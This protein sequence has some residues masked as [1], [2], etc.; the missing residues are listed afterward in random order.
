MKQERKNIPNRRRGEGGFS[1]IELLVVVAIIAIIAAIALVNGRRATEL[2]KEQLVAG[3]LHQLAE[4]EMQFRVTLGRRRYGTL[5]ELRAAQTGSGPL[6]PPTLAPVDGGGSPTAWQGWI[7]QDVNTDPTFLKSAFQIEAVA[8]AGVRTDSRYCVFEDGSVRR[9]AADAAC[10][11]SST[12][13][14]K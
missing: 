1:L 13:V 5:A 10:D 6:M 7:I 4:V 11:R 2:A 9:A 3:R 8:A 12:I 14:G